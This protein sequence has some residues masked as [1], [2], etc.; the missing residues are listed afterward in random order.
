MNSKTAATKK[1]FFNDCIMCV[2]M[3]RKTTKSS[4]D[5]KVLLSKTTQS[6]P[7]MTTN[8]RKSKIACQTNFFFDANWN[9]HFTVAIAMLPPPVSFNNL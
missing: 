8:A 3:S 2:S 9:F 6:K 7:L 1:H 4:D 5:D